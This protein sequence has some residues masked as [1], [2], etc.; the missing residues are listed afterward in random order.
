MRSFR[1]T[2]SWGLLLAA[3]LLTLPACDSDSGSDDQDISGVYT[4]T[5]LAFVTDGTNVDDV[6]VLAELSS[7]QFRVF[8]EDGGFSFEYQLDG[9][10]RQIGGSYDQDGDEVTFA[11]DGGNRRALLMPERFTLSIAESAISGES[12]TYTVNL[13]DFDEEFAESFEE[14]FGTRMPTGRLRV[15]LSPQ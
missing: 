10:L 4:V 14:S 7:P 11:L 12:S 1:S 5:E 15:A 9:R 3:L 2:A 13:N 6:N 8:A